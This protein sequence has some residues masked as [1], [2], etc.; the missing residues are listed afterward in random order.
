MRKLFI[1]LL[2]LL[3]VIYSCG[4]GGSSEIRVSGSSSVSPIMVKLAE[5]FEN[6]NKKYA[7][8]IETSD[9]TIGVQD[10]IAGKNNIGM[11]SRNIKEDE[12]KDVD[13]FVLC[14]D[15]LAII[16]NNASKAKEI[17]KDALAALYMKNTPYSG[18]TK[19]I[20]REDGSGTREAFSSLTGIGKNEALPKTVEILDGT[21]KVKTSVASDE[22]KIGYI[23]LGAVD[24]NIK[25]LA[26]NDG[27]QESAVMANTENIKNGSYKLY[28]PFMLVTKK[29]AALSD[30]TKIFITFL[31]SAEAKNIM[32]QN[33]FIPVD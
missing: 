13:S 3:G 15:G 29:G 5:T 25:V 2:A 19:C 28:R 9:S 27:K 11:A 21:G 10:T 7:V 20:S 1:C 22:A 24:E 6:Q 14:N 26:Y 12:I 33:G 4:G 18:I 8:I 16:V 17:N 31:K 32:L 30:E 23:S